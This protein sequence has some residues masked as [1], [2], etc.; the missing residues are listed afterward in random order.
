MTLVLLAAAILAATPIALEAVRHESRENTPA[1]VA[2]LER[3]RATEQV[4]ISRA[5][6]LP[7]VSLGAGT[8][9]LYDTRDL[10]Q[11]LG[12]FSLSATVSQLLYDGGRWWDQIAL[13]G[14]LAEAQAGQA[15]E[16]RLASELEGVRRFY[17]LYLAQETLRVL[18]AHARR[19]EEQLDRARG[20]FEAGRGQKSDAYAAEVNLGNDRLGIQRQRAWIV[21]AQGML[22]IWLAHPGTEALV[23]ETP[24]DLSGRVAGSGLGGSSV[25]EALRVARE[26]RPLLRAVSARLRAA[27]RGLGVASSTYWPA[28]FLVVSGARQSLAVR[29]FFTDYARQNYA[30]AGVTVQW[31]LFDGGATSARVQQADIAR[32][33]V[34]LELRQAERELEAE[35]R[36]SVVQLQSQQEMT[37]I[38][39]ANVEAARNGLALA[40]GRFRAGVGSTLEVRDAQLK[41]TQAEISLLESRIGAEVARV[42]LDRAMGR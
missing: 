41:L 24:P 10:P 34:E 27:E 2:E 8:F 15:A 39:L 9:A 7:R 37:G 40:E 32:R 33:R 11:T 19:S 1:R 29:P 35:V 28:I 3:V 25:E 36:H 20:L 4:R 17:E 38:A 5:D 23:A 12:S 13:S 30:Y 16:Q 42:A 18:E 21:T 6:V 14:A 26:S 31:D 22:A